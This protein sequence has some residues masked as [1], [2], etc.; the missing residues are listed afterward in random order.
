ME[1]PS[2]VTPLR[3]IGQVM[4]TGE[5]VLGPKPYTGQRRKAAK[6]GHRVAMVDFDLFMRVEMTNAEH[7][8]YAA[9]VRHIPD[10]GGIESR[11]G[12]GEIAQMLGVKQPNVSRV[13][14]DLLERNLIRRVRQGVWLVNPHLVYNGEFVEWNESLSHWDEPVYAR[15]VD[16]NTGEVK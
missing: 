4:G 9:I 3:Q 10:R 2:N 14:K 8:V 12:V 5:P 16:Q 15:N 11:I 1:Q 13:I 6:K 7:Q